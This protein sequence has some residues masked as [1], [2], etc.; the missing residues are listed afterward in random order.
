MV[1]YLISCPEK[2]KNFGDLAITGPDDDC[3]ISEEIEMSVITGIVSLLA[4]S[5]EAEAKW[6]AE[7]DIEIE[8]VHEENNKKTDSKKQETP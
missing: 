3:V 7:S 8:E 5:P 1:R 2:M 4:V 6:I